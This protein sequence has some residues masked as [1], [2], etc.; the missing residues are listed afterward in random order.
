[1]REQGNVV[2]FAP[3]VTMD[4]RKAESLQKAPFLQAGQSIGLAAMCVRS[5]PLQDIEDLTIGVETISCMLMYSATLRKLGAD[6]WFGETRW[7]MPDDE[8]QCR[9]IARLLITPLPGIGGQSRGK[10]VGLALAGFGRHTLKAG[11]A[12]HLKRDSP[13]RKRLSTRGGG[14]ALGPARTRG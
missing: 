2:P 4:V 14:N 6:Y 12:P 9:I 11:H 3:G 10:Q 1:M 13:P 7:K 8:L 5:H